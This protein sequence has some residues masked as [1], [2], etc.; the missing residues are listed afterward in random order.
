MPLL[1]ARIDFDA[2]LTRFRMQRENMPPVPAAE[3]DSAPPPLNEGGSPDPVA[4]KSADICL[5]SSRKSAGVVAAHPPYSSLKIMT[6]NAHVGMPTHSILHYILNS[7][8]HLLPHPKRRQNLKEIV[9]AIQ[10]FDLVALQELDAGSFRSHHINQLDFLAA[11]GRFPYSLQKTTRNFGRLAQHAKGL[12]SRYPIHGVNHYA[13]PSKMPGRGINTFCIGKESRPLFI[14]N[15]HLSL[16][17]KA[18]TQQ[19]AFIFN[20]AQAYEH[21]IIMG[22]FNMSQKEIDQSGFDHYGLHMA[23]KGVATYPSW[24]PKKQLDYILLSRSIRVKNAGVLPCLFSD[25]LPV[26]AEIEL[27]A[28]FDFLNGAEERTRTSTV[29]PAST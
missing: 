21:V 24:K 14:V 16:G 10:S 2:I 29:L 23:L 12:L 17:K 22:D 3:L 28:V 27:P 9:K 26:Y 19:L 7:W 13:L 5:L 4:L 8:H 11:Q 6:Y 25:H 1:Q 20:L 15:V 18:R